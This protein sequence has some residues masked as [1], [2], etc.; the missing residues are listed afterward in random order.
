ML[1]ILTDGLGKVW[2][3]CEMAIT[4]V[5]EMQ[6]DEKGKKDTHEKKKQSRVGKRKI[7]EENS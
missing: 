3:Y 4:A 6:L 5:G 1:I 7:E 2:V